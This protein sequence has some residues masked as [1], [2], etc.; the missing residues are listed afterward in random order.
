MRSIIKF[1]VYSNLFIATCA[2]ALTYE[3]FLLL[4]LPGSLNW[5]LLLIF[6]CTVFVYCLHY[7]IRL[8]TKKTDER[9]Q[10]CRQHKKL[11]LLLIALSLFFTIGGVIYHFNSVF[12]K[13]GHFDYGN[14]A[15]FI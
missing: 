12:G 2:L 11:L 5:Y 15:W 6:L 13:P 9:S 3:S 1:F 7:Y 4:H 8:E 14:L 10:W